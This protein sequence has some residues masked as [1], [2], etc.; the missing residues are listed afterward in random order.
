MLGSE[1]IC[2]VLQI[3][4]LE[5]K[6]AKQ[7]TQGHIANKWQRSSNPDVSS[8]ILLPWGYGSNG[9]MEDHFHDWLK[10]RAPML[11]GEDNFPL[12][13]F[14][15][16]LTLIILNS[17]VSPASTLNQRIKVVYRLAQRNTTVRSYR[18]Q[19]VWNKIP[20]S[21]SSFISSFL[22][23]YLITT[24]LVTKLPTPRIQDALRNETKFLSS[25]CLYSSGGN[26]PYVA[27]FQA[28]LL[29]FQLDINWGWS[30]EARKRLK[31]PLSLLSH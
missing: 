7:L 16:G 2:P 31:L 12:V 22:W 17:H 10:S 18:N 28:N 11:M 27:F 6:E 8:A 21:N 20:S 23:Q 9:A 29:F 4:N 14:L 5:L 13:S 1:D 19:G 15:S 25:W 3:K 30:R 24:H 26:R